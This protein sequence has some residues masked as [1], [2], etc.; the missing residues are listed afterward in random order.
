MII[1]DVYDRILK[2]VA[3]CYYTYFHIIRLNKLRK[4]IPELKISGKFVGAQIGYLLN[5]ISERYCCIKL[6]SNLNYMT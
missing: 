5:T 4:T 3:T 6:L 2:G 1:N